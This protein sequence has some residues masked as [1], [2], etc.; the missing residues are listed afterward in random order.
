MPESERKC[1]EV[2][3]ISTAEY[4]TPAKRPAYSVLSCDKLKR[5]FGLQLPHWEESLK[6]VL[7]KP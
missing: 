4:P 5:T 1:R 6:Q 7:D 3:A 2:E